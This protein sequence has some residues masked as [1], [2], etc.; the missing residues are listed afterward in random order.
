MRTLPY[1][2]ECKSSYPFYELIAAF[3]CQAAAIGYASQCGAANS[4]FA[5]RVMKGRR[6]QFEAGKRE[7]A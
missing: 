6:V 2:V 4:D 5:Y 1:K 7:A 3:D